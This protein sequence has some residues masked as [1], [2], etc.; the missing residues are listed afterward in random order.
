MQCYTT[1]KGTPPNILRSI[2]AFG[3]GPASPLHQIFS[4]TPH[5]R[6]RVSFTRFNSI[7]IYCFSLYFAICQST[8][9]RY[10]LQVRH[11]IWLHI[12]WWGG[13]EFQGVTMHT[14]YTRHVQAHDLSSHRL[15]SVLTLPIKSRHPAHLWRLLAQDTIICLVILETFNIT[16]WTIGPHLTSHPIFTCHSCPPS[17]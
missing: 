15:S 3:R 16:S 12:L 13:S 6:T 9:A 10:L 8:R 1:P 14:Y 7:V 2:A 4:A 5:D 11:Y 17:A